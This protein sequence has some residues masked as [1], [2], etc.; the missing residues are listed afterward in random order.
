MEIG[1]LPST[2]VDIIL[3]HVHTPE[4]QSG[5]IIKRWYAFQRFQRFQRRKKEVSKVIEDL[6]N[7][8]TSY[9]GEAFEADSAVLT[10]VSTTF[11]L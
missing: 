3:A 10:L 4:D 5:N 2:V 7:L 8:S 11:C 9:E 6:K 1:D